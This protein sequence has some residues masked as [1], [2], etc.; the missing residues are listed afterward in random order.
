MEIR[1]VKAKEEGVIMRSVIFVIVSVILAF[2]SAC[3]VSEVNNINSNN[4]YGANGAEEEVKNS[5]DIGYETANNPTE[6]FMDFESVDHGGGVATSF[7]VPLD[8]DYEWQITQSWASHCNYCTDKGYGKSEDDPNMCNWTHSTSE[9]CTY[10]WDFSLPGN[11]DEGKSVL[12]TAD[13]VIKKAGWCGTWGNCVIVDHGSN[14]CSRYA[15]M[16]NNSITVKKG[17]GVCQGLILGKIGDTGAPGSFHLHFQFEDCKTTKPLKKG[18]TDGNGIPVCTIGKDIYNSKDKYSALKLTNQPKEACSTT[19]EFAKKQFNNGATL[20]VPSIKSVACGPLPNCPLI[21]NCN[22]NKNHIFSDDKDLTFGVRSAAQYLYGE[23]ALN[24]KDDGGLHQSD[25][26]TNAEGL[27]IAMYL[28]GQVSDCG[29]STVYVPFSDVKTTDWYYP[30]VAC[31]LQKG[32]VENGALLFWANSSLSFETAAKYLVKSAVKAG[33]I[34]LKNPSTGS[35]SKI[36]YDDSAYKYVETLYSYGAV[37]TNLTSYYPETSITR[38]QF[39]R[40]AANLSPCYCDNISCDGSCKCDQVNFSCSKDSSGSDVGGGTSGTSDGS[41]TGNSSCTPSCSGKQCGNDG[42]GGSCGNCGNGFFCN[43]KNYCQCMPK[44][45]E[46]TCGSDGC[47]GTCGCSSG[48]SCNVFGKCQKNCI[49]NC[50]GKI[51]G[52]DGCGGTC[53][54]CSYGYLC[55]ASGQCIPPAQNCKP[56]DCTGILCGPNGCGGLCDNCKDGLKCAAVPIAG[57][58]L[59]FHFCTP[60]SVKSK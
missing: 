58:S 43:S 3:E 5:D 56:I 44:C 9:Y 2:V 13:G 22:A 54:L 19:G 40:M 8:P 18:F 27:K 60:P 23:C 1:S 32:I 15:H 14:V 31:G 24:G 55:N 35:F 53:G 28:F 11:K 51:C 46:N 36:P 10:S 49:P 7:K 16:Q 38:G 25:I 57:M 29:N 30:L 6:D 47:S 37:D 17:D 59:P 45:Y 33:V 50:S 48:Y 41:K 52:A 42:C 39:V 34:T 12:A 20:P 26:M 21:M 4:Y